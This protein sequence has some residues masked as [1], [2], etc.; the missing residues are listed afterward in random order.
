MT[1][2]YSTIEVEPEGLEYKN[3]RSH[4]IYLGFQ[5]FNYII[6]HLHQVL[7]YTGHIQMTSNYSTIEVE[8][9]E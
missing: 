5:V 4:C 7:L 9:E 3:E 2:N 8:G 6:F 1:S